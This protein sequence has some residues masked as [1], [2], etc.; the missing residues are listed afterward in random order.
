MEILKCPVC[1]QGLSKYESKWQCKNNH[2]FDIA[3]QGHVNL[4]MSQTAKNKQ[5]G[6]EKMM[7]LARQNYL[8]KGYY[9]V[10]REKLESLVTSY[11]PEVILD[12]GCGEGYY[13]QD[14]SKGYNVIG[15]DISK[16]AIMRAAKRNQ[17]MTCI[18]ASTYAVPLLNETVDVAYCVFAP[19]SINEVSRVLVEGGIFIEVFPLERHLLDLKAV[20]YAKP[21]TNDENHNVYEGFDHVAT[22]RVTG[23]IY[24][25][26]NTDIYN[27]FTMTPYYHRTPE[28]GVQALGALESL[29]TEIG[30]GFAVYRKL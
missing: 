26:D 29:Q 5:H 16:D 4:L 7:V 2:Q 17:S 24:L 12:L 25:D 23:T 10:F 21:Y 11:N 28:K 27:L 6:D 8:D 30:F 3:K 22:H 20:L 19:F 1:N 14:L 18:V 13:A 15:V 9:G